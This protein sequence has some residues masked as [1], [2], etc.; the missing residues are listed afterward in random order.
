MNSWVALIIVQTLTQ[1]AVR[2]GELPTL[3]EPAESGYYHW[4]VITPSV[5]APG[6]DSCAVATTTIEFS[7][8]ELCRTAVT[9]IEKQTGGV[10]VSCVQ[11]R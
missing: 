7:T 6:T 4:Q 8:E 5:S 1:P 3:Q 11:V 9:V 10:S 2:H